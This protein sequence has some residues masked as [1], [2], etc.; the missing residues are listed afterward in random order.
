[1]LKIVIDI[2]SE[3][4]Y[5]NHHSKRL[6]VN[7]KTKRKGKKM[8]TKRMTIKAVKNDDGQY[9]LVADNGELPQEGA[10]HKTKKSAYA[11]AERLWPSNSV[12]QGKRISGGYSIVI[13]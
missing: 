2:A 5:T 4:R 13:D 6:K 9:Q 3:I 1:M 12:W 11:D 7:K 10:T 8:K